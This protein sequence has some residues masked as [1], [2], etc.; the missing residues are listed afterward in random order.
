MIDEDA[1]RELPDTPPVRRMGSLALSLLEEALEKRPDD[2][3]GRRSKAVALALAGRKREAIQLEVSVLSSA[4]SYELALDECLLYAI[5]VGDIRAAQ[6]PARQAVA[7]NPWSAVFHERL[8]YVE[9]QLADWKEALYQAREALRLNPFHRFVR[10]FVIQCL[11]HQKDFK[12][13][14][15]E[16]TTLIGLNPSE[17]E[18]LHRWFASRRQSHGS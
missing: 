16:F 14:E 13:A 17:R 5:E 11:L 7:V 15:E 8:A 6:A 10:M 4:P 12:H 9:L 1:G 18:S 2:L 3:V